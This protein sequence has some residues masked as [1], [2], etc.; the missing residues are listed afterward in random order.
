MSDS[1][2]SQTILFVDDDQMILT[3]GEEMLTALGYEV[4][5]AE[6]GER[7]IEI[8]AA[9]N[10]QIHLVILDLTMPRLG[11]GETYDRLKA[12]DPDVRALLSTG[13]ILDG[14]AA[15]II[16]RG[17]NGFI[18]KPFGIRELSDKIREVLAS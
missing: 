11:G 15:G 7:A 12:I 5:P 6:S 8:Y 4:I 14:E 13:Y 16:E 18:Q 2:G 9:G 10:R 1:A 17:C 3:V